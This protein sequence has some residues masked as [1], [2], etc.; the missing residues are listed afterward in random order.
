MTKFILSIA[1]F[2][3]FLPLP[4][5]QA[6]VESVRIRE[7]QIPS[8]ALNRSISFSIV[9][10]EGEAPPNGWPVLFI[11]HGHGRNHRTL[12]D[13]PVCQVLLLRQPYIIVLPDTQTGWWV[14]S[15]LRKDSRYE[16]MLEEVL[17]W[18]KD[19]GLVSSSRSR[20]GIAGWSMGGYGATRFAARHPEQFSFL[21]TIIGL[22][23]FPRT[24][25]LSED[26]RYPIPTSIFGKNE[27]NWRA[28]NPINDIG[29]LKGYDIVI[30]LAERAFDRTMNENF[31]EAAGK[32]GFPVTVHRLKG[33][34]TFDSVKEGFEILLPTA[35]RHLAK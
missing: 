29:N 22:L 28:L 32:V 15:P 3:S 25:G 12:L 33:G 9:T 4:T 14:D 10:P 7:I 30:I 16:A 34:H 11:L 21:G 13:D 23:D 5:S 20:W 1:T 35:A 8:K 6:E 19:S 17:N 26:Q 18:V 24:D 31:L 2:C 27:N